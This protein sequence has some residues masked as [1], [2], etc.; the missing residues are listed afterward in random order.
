MGGVIRVRVHSGGNTRPC[1]N[2]TVESYLNAG[3]SN[4][5]LRISHGDVSLVAGIGRHRLRISDTVSAANE[6][7]DQLVIAF[8]GDLIIPSLGIASGYVGSIIP[9]IPQRITRDGSFPITFDIEVADDQ[10]RR[11]EDRRP[12]NSD[13]GLDLV[14][15]LRFETIDAQ[16]VISHGSGQLQP[17]KFV[18]DAWLEGLREVGFRHV[19]VIEL[20]VID[21]SANPALARAIEFFKQAQTR[22]FNGEYREVAESLRQSLGA[23]VGRS[24]DEESDPEQL[25]RDLG[26]LQREAHNS[27]IGYLP[28][29]EHVRRAL[30]FTA[31]LGAHPEAG[32]TNRFDALAQMHM[33]AGL[34]QWYAKH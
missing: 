26:D 33:T 18:R 25:G 21:S 3:G 30:K 32:E 9:T 22:Y 5:G 11:I 13:G 12:V 4:A 29:I 14:L 23:I 19:Q 16:N 24:G 7:A 1:Y 10:I 27:K 31:D 20:E 15:N 6:R 17:H 2:V 28:R 8:T 34:I